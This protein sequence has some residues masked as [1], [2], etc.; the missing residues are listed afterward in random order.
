MFKFGK[1]LSPLS[2]SLT[3][4][5]VGAL[6]I[7]FSD[8]WVADLAFNVEQL[9]LM[10]SYKGW[11][12]IAITTVPLYFLI[13]KHRNYQIEANQLLASTERRYEYLFLNNPFPL[14]VC[15]SNSGEP[16]FFN[17]AMMVTFGYSMK[18]FEKLTLFDL[19]PPSEQKRLKNKLS[20]SP[21]VNHINI[22]KGIK[23]N[24]SEILLDI[25][26]YDVQIEG[27][28]KLMFIFDDVTSDMYNREQVRKLT[29]NLER[30]VAE[31]TL[32]LQNV[33]DELEAF[34]YSVSHD[35]RAPLR[36]I[37][38]FSLAILDEASDS[39]SKQSLNHL[40]RVRSA[41]Q[42]MSDLIDD[43][44][45]LSR[46]TKASLKP[47]I[48]NIS[49]ISQIV[50]DEFCSRDPDKTYKITIQPDLEAFA[51]EGHI[52]ILLENL[53]SNAFK[54]TSK[55][56]SPEIDVGMVYKDGAKVFFVKDNGVGFDTAFTDKLFKPFQR[57]HEAS[58]FPGTG[59]GLATVMRIIKR[60]NGIIYCD[61]VI[62]GGTTFFFE[63]PPLMLPT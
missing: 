45:R 28:K 30:K 22:F 52:T 31:R 51:D 3:Y 61:S 17:K 41:S 46:I 34:T 19:F 33:N 40:H 54:Y 58:E 13:K 55:K 27:N 38:G 63:I 50:C 6:W 15:R 56:V 20:I 39:L 10:Q 42:K 8:K 43:L 57:L 60:H 11:F 62:D 2:I 36:A 21:R 49:E 7:T 29:E 35:L 23:K 4:F 32:E 26:L 1:I 59:V 44:L 48:V 53:L 37:D 16:V 9:A 18:E 12:Y 47:R 5:F 25:S 14:M 24:G